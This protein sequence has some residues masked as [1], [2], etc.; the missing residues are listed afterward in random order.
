MSESI[1]INRHDGAISRGNRRSRV[2]ESQSYDSELCVVAGAG[3]SG[4]GVCVCVCVCVYVCH[5]N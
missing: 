4:G 5:L 3:T 2:D 1:G